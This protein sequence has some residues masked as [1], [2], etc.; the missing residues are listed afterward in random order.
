MKK[1]LRFFLP[2]AD[3]DPPHGGRIGRERGY[4]PHY[5]LNGGHT[6]HIWYLGE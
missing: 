5:H 3:W 4:L 1:D 2:G 6:C